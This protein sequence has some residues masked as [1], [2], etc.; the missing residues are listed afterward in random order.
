MIRKTDIQV[1]LD[2]LSPTL[3]NFALVNVFS[4]PEG[5]FETLHQSVI[6]K[7]DAENLMQVPAGYF[8]NFAA[9]MLAKVK[10]ES[11]FVAEEE[12]AGVLSGFSKKNVFSVPDGYFDANLQNLG[13]ITGSSARVI[14]MQ[15]KRGIVKYLAAAAVAGLV[16]L[17]LF[18]VFNKDGKEVSNDNVAT[19]QMASKIIENN[20]F[21]KELNQLDGA[22]I[23]AYLQEHGQDVNAALVAASTD[24][25][26][27][28]APLDYIIDD[29]TLNDFLKSEGFSN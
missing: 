1:E 6:A 18:T 10:S 7:R 19:M 3:A 11:P 12:A 16:G 23:E 2:T 17:S 22:T 4:V 20:S 9:Q 24:G 27:L 26:N 8:E 25:S 21:D 15:P 5:Y 28:P 29:N 13:S 14:K